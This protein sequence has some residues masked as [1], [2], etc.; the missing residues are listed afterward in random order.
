M[1]RYVGLLKPRLR[2]SLCS[3][4]QMNPRLGISWLELCPASGRFRAH[5]ASHLLSRRKRSRD[6]SNGRH[7]DFPHTAQ[8]GS[9]SLRITHAAGYVIFFDT[10]QVKSRSSATCSTHVGHRPDSKTHTKRV[11]LGLPK[12][13]RCVKWPDSHSNKP[14][15]SEE[16]TKISLK[17]LRDRILQFYTSGRG[18]RFFSLT[19]QS[20]AVSLSRNLLLFF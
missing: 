7:L 9:S 14:I 4:V 19:L 17:D 10:L 11:C 15:S 20:M 16:T 1:S 12:W 6:P 5:A 3:S 2:P 8:T 18:R 13:G